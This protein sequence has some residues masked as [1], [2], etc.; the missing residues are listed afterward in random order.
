M[1]HVFIIT[2]SRI[3][4]GKYKYFWLDTTHSCPEID[5]IAPTVLASASDDALYLTHDIINPEIEACL[6]NAFNRHQITRSI[7]NL[8][9]NLATRVEIAENGRTCLQFN[10]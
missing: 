1:D 6:L 7:D 8:A 10:T 5:E 2:S 3:V 4:P 9:D